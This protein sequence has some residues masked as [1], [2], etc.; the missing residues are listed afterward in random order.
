[1]TACSVV[2][3]A[4][5]RIAFDHEDTTSSLTYA[6]DY[7]LG[8]GIVGVIGLLCWSWLARMPVS[9]GTSCVWTRILTCWNRSSVWWKLC[10]PLAALWQLTLS[11]SHRVWIACVWRGCLCTFAC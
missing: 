4:V 1:M 5:A 11:T 9:C 10:A 6:F 3:C 7:G 8:V 2:A